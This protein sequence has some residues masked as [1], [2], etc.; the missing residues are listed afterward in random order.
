VSGRSHLWSPWQRERTALAQ[1]CSQW[2][3]S[4]WCAASAW[5]GTGAPRFCLVC[6]PSVR[7]EEHAHVGGTGVPQ[8]AGGKGLDARTCK[9]TRNSEHWARA[10]PYSSFLDPFPDLKAVFNITREIRLCQDSQPALA[11]AD[12]GTSW[13]ILE[14]NSVLPCQYSGIK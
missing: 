2:I 8:P 14:P 11:P 12:F 6:I 4:S 5:I 3:S 13:R 9:R 7:G 1:R 10:C